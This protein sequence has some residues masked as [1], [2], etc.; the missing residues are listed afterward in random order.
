ML[1]CDLLE[2][3]EYVGGAIASRW[4]NTYKTTLNYGPEMPEMRYRKNLH[5]GKISFYKS[6]RSVKLALNI[7]SSEALKRVVS[8]KAKKN[9]YLIMI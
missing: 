6:V 1:K 7:L 5:A 3:R 9:C 8:K 2:V 4:K